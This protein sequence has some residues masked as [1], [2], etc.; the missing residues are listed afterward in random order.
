MARTEAGFARLANTP[1]HS[2]DERV[3]ERAHQPRPRGQQRSR[4]AGQG[5]G[6]AQTDLHRP[7]G[8]TPAH[9]SRSPRG[10]CVRTSQSKSRCGQSRSTKIQHFTSDRLPT[11]DLY[12]HQPAGIDIDEYKRLCERWRRKPDRYRQAKQTAEF[13]F[14]GARRAQRAYLV[15]VRD[16]LAPHLGVVAVIRVP[17]PECDSQTAF[18]RFLGR[19]AVAEG[20]TDQVPPRDTGPS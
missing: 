5:P 11:L 4:N 2:P 9:S 18:E 8:A 3:L 20:V 17:A 10:R 12:P 6:R 13:A 19:A 1:R 7:P 16:L 15:A 14:A